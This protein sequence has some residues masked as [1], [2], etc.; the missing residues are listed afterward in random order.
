MHVEEKSLGRFRF[1]GYVKSLS[2]SPDS[3]HVAYIRRDMWRPFRR[4]EFLVV[5]GNRGHSY[6]R[7]LTDTVRFDALGR[8]VFAASDHGK[9]FC[10]VGEERGESYESVTAPKV[11]QNGRRCA[12]I[13]RRASRAAVIADEQT[14]PWFESILE[15][16]LVFSPDSRHIGYVA[17]RDGQWRCVIDGAEG[18]SFD[19]VGEGSL[20]FNHD[21]SRFAYTARHDR[22]WRA[23]VDGVPQQPWYGIADGTPVFAPTGGNFAYAAT[24][25]RQRFVVVDAHVYGPY[26]GVGNNLVFSNDGSQFAFRARKGREWTVVSSPGVSSAYENISDA[27]PILSAL[28]NRIA[29]TGHRSGKAILVIDGTD[30]FVHDE[31]VHPTFGHGGM[32]IAY[33]A[34]DGRRWSV[35]VDGRKILDS[36]EGV[37]SEIVFSPDDS[38]VAVEVIR[39]YDRRSVAV[40][41]VDGRECASVDFFLKGARPTW[42]SPA[43]AHDL[44]CRGRDYLFIH[45]Q[46]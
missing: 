7:I 41:T 17:R 20:S 10:L 34:R 36:N 39:S 29:F 15:A 8:P 35:F 13:A 1:G 23:I 19:G 44:G 9:V 26:D 16:L 32:R 11:S 28:G 14:G 18:P 25:G 42:G 5:D 24:D 3:R 31:I 30:A 43:T 33:A 27:T 22:T 40:L 46:T 21:G 12:Y 45:V 37:S 6:D 2:V 4:R 38:H